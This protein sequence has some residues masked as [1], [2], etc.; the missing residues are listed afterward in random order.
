MAY[1]NNIG[2]DKRDY[3]FCDEDEEDDNIEFYEYLESEELDREYSD[4]IVEKI[5]YFIKN[6][7]E[8]N[9]VP[10]FEK[11]TMSSL[12]EFLSEQFTDENV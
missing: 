10:F 7:S 4:D 5:F 3:S 2:Y 9:M 6:Y 12:G 8:E 11:M 1:R